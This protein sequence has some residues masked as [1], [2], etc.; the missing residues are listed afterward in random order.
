[1]MEQEDRELEKL[2]EDM[3][4]RMIAKPAIEEDSQRGE[5]EGH[6]VKLVL[7]DRELEKIV[8]SKPV[9]VVLFTSP[10]CPACH[11]YRPIFYHYAGEARRRYGDKVEFVEA[12]V[13]HVYD[14][15]VELGIS[16][17][18]TTVVFLRCQPVDGFVGMVDEETLA[19]IVEPYIREA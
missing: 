11:A 4:R 1:M 17:T 2:I 15:A 8:C 9:A 18:P 3:V 10:G 14:K 12:D 16:A 7:D 13:Y 6:P 19:E 5:G